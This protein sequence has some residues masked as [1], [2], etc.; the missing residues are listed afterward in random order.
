ML[1]WSL[2]VANAIL[3]ST[4][5]S[6]ERREKKKFKRIVSILWKW[7]KWFSW[8]ALC[9]WAS[10]FGKHIVIRR[11]STNCFSFYFIFIFCT[12]DNIFLKFH[13]QATKKS[14]QTWKLS[15]PLV[16]FLM[17][18]SKSCVLVWPKTD[19]LVLLKKEHRAEQVNMFWLLRMTFQTCLS[20]SACLWIPL[21]HQ[22]NWIYRKNRL[23][24]HN[25][26]Y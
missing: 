21:N 2:F 13:F 19:F 26:N 9:I 20:L 25:L 15:I 22:T 10:L 18:L 4:A 8:S 1:L 3:N 12:R 7:E 11:C 5:L 23:I 24:S 17:F 6:F 14:A 16:F